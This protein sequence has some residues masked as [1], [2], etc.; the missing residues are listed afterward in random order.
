MDLEAKEN[1]KI[2][3]AKILTQIVV[4]ARLTLHQAPLVLTQDQIQVQ[5]GHA[6][7]NYNLRSGK[8][9]AK[10]RMTDDIV[11][12]LLSAIFFIYFYYNTYNS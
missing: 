1:R 6:T 2:K 8:N 11:C 7:S 3:S 9:Q 10:E 12:S 5:T 4:A